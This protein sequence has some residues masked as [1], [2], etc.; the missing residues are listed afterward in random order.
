MV[1]RLHGVQLSTLIRISGNASLPDFSSLSKSNLLKSTPTDLIVFATV[2]ITEAR[3]RCQFVILPL[4]VF[5]TFT[6]I[7]LLEDAAV[8]VFGWL[9]FGIRHVG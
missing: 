9:R 4:S 8:A 7:S 1:E 3:D 6:N 5:Y 2:A